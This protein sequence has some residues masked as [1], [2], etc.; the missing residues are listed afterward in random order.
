[1]DFFPKETLKPTRGM[2]EILTGQSYEKMRKLQEVSGAHRAGLGLHTPR[3]RVPLIGDCHRETDSE[4]QQ[5]LRKPQPDT[6]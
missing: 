2:D 3:Y 5:C 4:T 6:T 1:M